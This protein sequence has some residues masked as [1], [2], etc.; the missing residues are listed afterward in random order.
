M[1][2]ALERISQKI[3]RGECAK[4]RSPGTGQ[5]ESVSRLC[6]REC[7]TWLSTERAEKAGS[8]VLTLGDRENGVLLI[9]TLS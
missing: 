8:P 1:D 9:E 4:G 6:M 5:V 7:W 2:S 3:F